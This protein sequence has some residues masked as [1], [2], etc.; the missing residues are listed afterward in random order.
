[1][2]TLLVPNFWDAQCR[3]GGGDFGQELGRLHGIHS[4]RF[5]DGNKRA[6]WLAMQTFL[7]GNGIEIAFDP[8]EAVTCTVQLAYGGCP[9]KI[10]LPGCAR[11]LNRLRPWANDPVGSASAR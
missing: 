7:A 5:V 10:S 4:H 9:K 11:S 6:A 2:H 8:A 1:M 3:A